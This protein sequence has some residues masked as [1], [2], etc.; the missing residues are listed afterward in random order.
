MGKHNELNEVGKKKKKKQTNLKY[1][2]SD[3]GSQGHRV[4]DANP[5]ELSRTRDRTF[6]ASEAFESL[7][8]LDGGLGLLQ[9]NLVDRR[10]G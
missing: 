3:S 4:E 1:G 5:V 7:P 2:N 6:P 8:E 10:Q 9:H